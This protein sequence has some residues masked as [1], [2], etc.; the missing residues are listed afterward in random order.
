[1][2]HSQ[3]VPHHLITLFDMPVRD[4]VNAQD[5]LAHCLLR[6]RPAIK[7]ISVMGSMSTS[8]IALSV[9]ISGPVTV[10]L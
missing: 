6:Q 8:P 7:N 4:P 5:V 2:Q 3:L 1:M 9:P 10:V